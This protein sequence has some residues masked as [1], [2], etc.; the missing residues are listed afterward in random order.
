MLKLKL[1]MIVHRRALKKTYQN[2]INTVIIT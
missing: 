2:S 1:V